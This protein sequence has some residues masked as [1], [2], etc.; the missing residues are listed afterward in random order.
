MS[1]A[2]AKAG[3][4]CNADLD[5]DTVC[6]L[7][8][9]AGVAPVCTKGDVLLPAKGRRATVCSPYNPLR[10]FDVAARIPPA[11][12]SAADLTLTCRNSTCVCP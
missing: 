2:R 12:V 3:E 1:N 8:G 5:Q 11:S 7:N 9:D 4:E 10:E 6:W